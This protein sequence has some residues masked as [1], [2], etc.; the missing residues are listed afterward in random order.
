MR[1][2]GE[3]CGTES[4]RTDRGMGFQRVGLFEVEGSGPQQVWLQ[5]RGRLPESDEA[6]VAHC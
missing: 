2:T 1:L 6:G 4:A 5:D 3:G